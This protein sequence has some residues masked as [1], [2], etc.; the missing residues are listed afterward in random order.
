MLVNGVNMDRHGI[1]ST[2][3][4]CVVLDSITWVFC[5]FQEDGHKISHLSSIY[6]F[7][8]ILSPISVDSLSFLLILFS[9]CNCIHVVQYKLLFMYVLKKSASAK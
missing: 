6:L 4:D 8:K 7:S 1:D 2:E 9:L 3:A 5:V